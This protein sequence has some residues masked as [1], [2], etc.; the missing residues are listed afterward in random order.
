MPKG[1]SDIK[2]VEAEIIK[3]CQNCGKDFEYFTPEN[4]YLYHLY[5]DNFKAEEMKQLC[6]E[7]VKK[8]LLKK[9]IDL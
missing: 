4:S 3:F 9:K 5:F 7:C 1:F 2:K 6:P 8:E